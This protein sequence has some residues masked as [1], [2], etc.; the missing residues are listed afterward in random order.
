MEHFIE[1]DV[2]AF[3]DEL[4]QTGVRGIDDDE[5]LYTALQAYNSESGYISYAIN[6]SGHS[7]FTVLAFSE[8]MAQQMG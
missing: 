7:D 2:R 4:R 5:R 8:M 1:E 6:N 3:A